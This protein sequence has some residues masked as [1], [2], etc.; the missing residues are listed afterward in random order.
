[1]ANLLLQALPCRCKYSVIPNLGADRSELTV[2]T[3]VRLLLRE[4]FLIFSLY[5]LWECDFFLYKKLTESAPRILQENFF[6][7]FY[8]VLSLDFIAVAYEE[9]RILLRYFA[10]LLILY[11]L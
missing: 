8:N 4:T 9:V 1:M 11:F 3:H 7:F 10:I 6:L 5:P 2:H